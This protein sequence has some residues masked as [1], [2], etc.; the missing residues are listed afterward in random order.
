[1]EIDDLVKRDKVLQYLDGL[2]RQHHISIAKNMYDTRRT[3]NA[4]EYLIPIYET[5]KRDYDALVRDKQKQIRTL[6]GMYEYLDDV[7]KQDRLLLNKTQQ[8][9]DII[10]REIRNLKRELDEMRAIDVGNNDTLD[11]IYND[12]LSDEESET[13]S[14]ESSE[15]SYDEETRIN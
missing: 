3:M 7:L 1:M 2:E 13:S 5:Y 11:V 15:S 4:N 12:D 8:D 14:S 6:E 10:S 9:K